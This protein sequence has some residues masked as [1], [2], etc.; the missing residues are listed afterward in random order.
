MSIAA[1][2]YSKIVSM[3]DIEAIQPIFMQI[4]QTPCV[5]TDVIDMHQVVKHQQGACVLCLYSAA[6]Y[7]IIH[8]K[9]T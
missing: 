9:Y 8:I 2:T 4:C 7:S 5:S 6:S 3:A 1:C